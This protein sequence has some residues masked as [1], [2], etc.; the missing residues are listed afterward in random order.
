MTKYL[1]LMRHGETLFNVQHKIQ[2]WSD[3]P[4]TARGVAQAKIAGQYLQDAGVVFDHAYSSTAERAS[5]TLELVTQGKLPYQR[6][7]GLREWGFG[8]YEGQDESLN[9]ALPYGDFFH[10]FGGETETEVEQ[11]IYSTILSLMPAI[12][13]AGLVVSHGGACANFLRRA[14]DHDGHYGITNCTIF[15]L[16]YTAGQFELLATIHPDFSSLD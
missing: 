13:H 9:P 5:D 2:G 6:V 10:Q 16:A 8:V 7:K 4:L 3:S 11:R 12:D 14:L 1:Y 15:K